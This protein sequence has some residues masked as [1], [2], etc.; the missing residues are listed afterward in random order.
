MRTARRWWWCRS[1]HQALLR[2]RQR[3]LLEQSRLLFHQVIE[4]DNLVLQFQTD[5]V[6]QKEVRVRLLELRPDQTR[7]RRVDVG[8][9]LQGRDDLRVDASSAA[10][11]DS[12][13]MASKTKK[14]PP[15]TSSP[16]DDARL[17][18]EGTAKP[19]DAGVDLGLRHVL[20]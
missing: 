4:R 8:L 1:V 20:T 5:V 12:V 18:R 14:K 13:R 15:T 7:E 6:T 2:Q 3:Q 16:R 11:L 9:D 10:S 19:R 17:W